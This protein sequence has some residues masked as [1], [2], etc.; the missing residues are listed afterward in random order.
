MQIP[1]HVVF[2]YGQ[3]D[4][5]V[6]T[7]PSTTKD[8]WT[9]EEADV[10]ITVEQR[11][12][13]EP[14]GCGAGRKGVRF[15]SQAKNAVK[16]ALDPT[17]DLQPIHNLC[18]AISTLQSPQRDICLSLLAKEYAKQKYG[19]LIFPMKDPPMNTETW[20]IC[21]LRS[22]LDDPNFARR[23]RLQLAVTLASSVLQLHETSWL[24]EDWGKDDI[25]FITRSGK[26]GYDDPFLSQG[27][28]V[29]QSLGK[30]IPISMRRI[31][32]N[33]ALYA[34]GVSLIE[35]W[36]G[37][38]LSKLQHPDDGPL[39]TGNAQADAMTEWNTADRIV[40]ELYSDAGG[41]YADAVRRCIRCDFD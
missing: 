5:T 37:K 39:G 22:A 27:D 1:F 4:Q 13:A 2:R 7:N 23:S 35:L 30:C 14:L 8:H 17:P 32:R 34:L 3:T 16:A 6:P 33:R 38:S 12:Q 10:Q 9:W 28:Q 11:Q 20:S 36:Y 29:S 19:I 21:S 31:I 15:A 24:N 40:D 41:K 26:T 18:A 25:L